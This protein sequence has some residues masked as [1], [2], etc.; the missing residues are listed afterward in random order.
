MRIIISVVILISIPI[1]GY[2]QDCV[3]IPDK[4]F[5]GVA[6]TASSDQFIKALGEP[7][8]QIKM[9]NDRIAYL[10][11]PRL[12]LIFWYNKLWEVYS[13]ETRLILQSCCRSR[14]L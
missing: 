12:L 7:D 6:I 11:G 14:Y 9:G 10:Y 3:L 8:G 4:S 1:L 2:T 5:C 13:W